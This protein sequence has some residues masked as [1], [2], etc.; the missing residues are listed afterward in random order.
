M[1][2]FKCEKCGNTSGFLHVEHETR[3][4]QD[5]YNKNQSLAVEIMEEESKFVECE[6]C[7]ATSCYIPDWDAGYCYNYALNSV[8]E[9]KE[10]EAEKTG[11]LSD[12]LHSFNKECCTCKHKED[13]DASYQKTDNK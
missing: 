8:H 3:I 12:V 7:G 5:P 13:W 10:K 2:A 4:M 11:T 1:P 9:P 6:H